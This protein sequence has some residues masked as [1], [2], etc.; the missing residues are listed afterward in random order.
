MSIPN[1]R[2]IKKRLKELRALVDT[3]PD[4]AVQ[5]I[6]YG[7]ETAIRW[8]TEDTVGWTPPAKDAVE[9]ARLLYGEIR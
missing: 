5:R 7:M 2:T 6:A 8:A 9:L 1:K 3:H 4:P